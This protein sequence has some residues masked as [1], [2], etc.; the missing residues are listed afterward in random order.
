[1][2]KES[3]GEKF[4]AMLAVGIFFLLFIGVLGLVCAIPLAYLLEYVFAPAVLA[5]VFGTA[6]IS[7]WKAWAIGAVFSMLF[8]SAA[9]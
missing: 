3:A 8:K 2:A 4:G 9:K 1:M 6:S 7:I 5:T